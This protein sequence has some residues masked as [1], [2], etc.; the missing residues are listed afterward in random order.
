MWDNSDIC[1]V[2]YD[3]CLPII[4]LR[5]ELN[6]KGFT[7]YQN[8]RDTRECKGKGTPALIQKIDN[9]FKNPA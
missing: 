6:G 9:I 5:T 3:D 7:S 1:F 8:G 4:K 2:H